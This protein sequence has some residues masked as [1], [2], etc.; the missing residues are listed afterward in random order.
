M[1]YSSYIWSWSLDELQWFHWKF[2]EIWL[3]HIC[4]NAYLR[5]EFNCL[6]KF[7]HFSFHSLKTGTDNL[8]SNSSYALFCFVEEMK[9]IQFIFIEIWLVHYWEN[10]PLKFCIFSKFFNIFDCFHKSKNNR[11]RTTPIYCPSLW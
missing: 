2:T 4:E 1:S 5:S 11:G 3:V 10:G 9:W 8:T 7:Y 6:S